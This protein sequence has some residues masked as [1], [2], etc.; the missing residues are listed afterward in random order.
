MKNKIFQHL[1][2]AKYGS[3][4]ITTPENEIIQIGDNSHNLQAKIKINDW[5]LI[6]LMISKGDI[7]FGEAYIEK[8]YETSNIYDVLLFFV[9]NQEIL[10]PIFHG[11]WLYSTIFNIKNFFK[12]N[13]LKGSKKNIEYHYDLGNDF[14]SLW[15]DKT[16]SYSSGIFYQDES[17][18]NSQI[19]KYQKIIDNLNHNGS[20]I[21]EIGCGWG[22]FINQASANNFHIKGLTLSQEQKK[23]SEQL[24]KDKNLNAKIALQDYRLE[25]GKF[26]NIVSIEMFEAVGKKYWD[27]YF[28]KIKQCLKKEGRA[29]I[30]TITIADEFYKKYLKTSDYI[31]EYIFPG[32]FLPTPSIFRNLAK[33]HNLQI[34]DEFNF[35]QSYSK[36][37]L[38]WLDNFNNVQSEVKKLGYNNQFIRKWQFYLAYCAAG[39]S[40]NK[41]DVIQF[42]LTHDS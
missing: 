17:L 24:I 34:T 7:G 3:L 10:D 41:T 14:Y 37:L 22:G 8:I 13:S 12:K 4:E 36:T 15:L 21:L 27:S 11:N 20:E 18:E 26:D 2:K 30:Q 33:S 23:Y 6:D 9:L 16:M 28:T 25:N 5:H 29:V 39:F 1:E 32:G 38:K 42:S 40:S 35:A 19:N 31:R